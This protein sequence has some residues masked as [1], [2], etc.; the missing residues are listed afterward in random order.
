LNMAMRRL[1]ERKI[2]LTRGGGLCSAVGLPG[3]LMT[4]GRVGS[5]SSAPFAH[6]A[7]QSADGNRAAQ[8]T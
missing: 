7:T 3:M 6:S 5:F 2:A 4:G 1:L 8:R